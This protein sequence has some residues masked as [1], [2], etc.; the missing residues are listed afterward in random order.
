[1]TNHS[2]FRLLTLKELKNLLQVNDDRT[3]RKYYQDI[4][5]T[6]GAPKVL[7]IHFLQYFKIQ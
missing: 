7:Y 2:N 4:K 5:I 3:A 6:S 1:M